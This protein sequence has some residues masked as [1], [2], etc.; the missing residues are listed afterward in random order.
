MIKFCK[1]CGKKNNDWVGDA[2]NIG[3]GEILC[4]KCAEEI[5][6]MV[7]CAHYVTNLDEY[8]KLKT[9]VNEKC[10]E[11]FNEE[12]LRLVNIR[13]DEIISETNLISKEELE[14]NIKIQME[15]EEEYNEKLSSLIMTTGSVLE[16]YKVEQYIDVIYEE[17]I[18]KNS[19]KNRLVAGLEDLGNAWS[20]KETE[21]TGANELIANARKYVLNKFRKHAVDVKANAVLGVE[22]ESSIGSDVVR[23]AVFGT[24]VKVTKS[25]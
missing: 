22:F 5:K 12:I 15:T 8:E 16:G 24:A 10:Q 7:I 25:E 21:L 14:K 18:F 19:F 17:V 9:K 4:Y 23:V 3:C 13:I 2:L 11:S 6:P 20:F 1:F